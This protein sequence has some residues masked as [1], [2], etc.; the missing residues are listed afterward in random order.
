MTYHFNLDSSDIDVIETCLRNELHVRAEKYQ[1]LL[2]QENDEEMAR[3][4]Q[5][6]SEIT[7]LLGKIHTQKLWWN[8]A[9]APS[10]VP[11]G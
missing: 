1:E 6:V 8:A 9:P 5:D 7:G 3:S 10:C 4:K 2:R 11:K